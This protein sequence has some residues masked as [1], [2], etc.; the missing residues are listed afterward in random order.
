MT[1]NSILTMLSGIPDCLAN[2]AIS[3]SL[4]SAPASVGMLRA[5]E[6]CRFSEAGAGKPFDGVFGKACKA[7]SS[8]KEGD[9][10]GGGCAGLTLWSVL[11]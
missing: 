6:F 1:L 2:L 9:E 3:S 11:G 7:F 4:S 10:R 5:T 8:D